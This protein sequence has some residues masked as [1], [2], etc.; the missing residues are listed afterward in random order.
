[1]SIGDGRFTVRHPTAGLG[2]SALTLSLVHSPRQNR[3]L[4]MTTCP[5]CDRTISPTA[6]NCPYCQ[7]ALKAHGHPGMT[8]HRASGETFLCDTCTYEADNTCNFPKRPT[9]KTCTL[10][11]NINAPAELGVKEIYPLPWWKKVN[12]FWAG[13]IV[14]V[15][16]SVIITIL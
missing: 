5:Q 4:A 13:M 12:R 9:A 7:L 15:V 2:S 10:Y 14:L 11:Q 8:L 6:I 1:M 3:P 16:V